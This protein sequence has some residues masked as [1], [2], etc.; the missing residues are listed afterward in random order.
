MTSLRKKVFEYIKKKYQVSPEYP[1]KRDETSAVFRHSDNNNKWFALC[2][3]V[4]RDKLGLGSY[5][6]TDVLNL[7][8]DDLFL[9]EILIREG[10]VYPAYHMSK[11]HWITVILDGSVPED[12]VFDLVDS[13]FMATA[14]A[15]KK[16]KIRPPKEWIIPS[17][18]KYYDVIQAFEDAEEIDW[19]QGRGI[20]TGDTVFLYVG[21]PVSAILYKCQVTETDIPY[22]FRNKNLTIK[23]LMKI[24]L[25][26]RYD[27]GEFTFDVLKSKYNI[28][29]VRGPRGIPNSL[30]A[31]LNKGK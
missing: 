15:K 18:P 27:P 30:S 5:E 10:G 3:K 20:K 2:M 21:A 24:R 31:A 12:K 14:S 11:M 29:A 17:N 1:W 19:K 4:S 8:M 28:F 9:R 7:K 13:S 6:D 22:D 23:A 25:L 26:K 16:E